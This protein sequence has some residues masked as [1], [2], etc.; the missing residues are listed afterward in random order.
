MHYERDD[1]SRVSRMPNY[2]V[3][4]LAR[5]F[6]TT[7]QSLLAQAT[8]CEAD[9]DNDSMAVLAHKCRDPSFT[10]PTSPEGLLALIT[11]PSMTMVR[12]SLA[13]GI[14]WFLR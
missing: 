5:P 10:T 12:L 11:E 7:W 2:Y 4:V 8:C 14:I 1:A 3:E 6:E 9:H 13:T